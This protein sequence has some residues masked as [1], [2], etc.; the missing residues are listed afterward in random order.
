M[1]RREFIM[2]L[3]GAAVWPLAARAQQATMRSCFPRRQ[4]VGLLPRLAPKELRHYSVV[5]GIGLTLTMCS[6]IP[7]AFAAEASTIIAVQNM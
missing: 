1:K 4:S 7:C 3:G 6:D 5:P 2:L